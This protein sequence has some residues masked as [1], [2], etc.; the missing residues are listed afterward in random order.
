MNG[1][2][3]NMQQM[4][5]EQVIDRMIANTEQIEESFLEKRGDSSKQKIMMHLGVLAA[6]VLFS[7]SVM[8]ILKNALSWTLG[9]LSLFVVL[10]TVLSI[11]G[12]AGIQAAKIL[13]NRKYYEDIF[14][15]LE[16]TARIKQHLQTYKRRLNQRGKD[17]TSS[18]EQEWNAKIS[19]GW[20]FQTELKEAE[21]K[22]STS[23]KRQ[24][25][26]LQQYEKITY[27]AASLS[28][29]LTEVFLFQETVCQTAGDIFG[30]GEWIETVYLICAL[31]AAIG[32]TFIGSYYWITCR[33]YPIGI[34]SFL[35]IFADGLFGLIVTL[36]VASIILTAVFIVIAIVKIVIE[37]VKIVLGIIV[38]ILILMGIL[39]GS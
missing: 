36:L 29:A 14:A 24:T 7:L 15:G 21:K 25:D 31:I 1:N 20:D 28:V 19:V 6:V 26:Y 4:Q 17:L 12:F 2:V 38:G 23:E 11:S 13:L 16:L 37:I 35:W 3:L 10:I 22:I 27:Y 33:Q 18:K 5:A 34:H 32:G 39:S 30:S 8:M 9:E